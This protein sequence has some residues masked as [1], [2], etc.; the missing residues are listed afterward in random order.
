MDTYLSRVNLDF[1]W[2]LVNEHVKPCHKLQGCH[3]VEAGW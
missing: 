1:L 2:V 3:K